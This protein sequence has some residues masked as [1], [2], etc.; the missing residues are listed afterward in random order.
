MGTSGIPQV[1]RL[2][3]W[4][5]GHFAMIIIAGQGGIY[6]HLRRRVTDLLADE[7]QIGCPERRRNCAGPEDAG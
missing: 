2:L 7:G 3:R 4:D 1:R 5:D 6:R